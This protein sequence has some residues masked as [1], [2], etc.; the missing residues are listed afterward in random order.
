[1]T[2]LVKRLQSEYEGDYNLALTPVTFESVA[3]VKGNMLVKPMNGVFARSLDRCIALHGDHYLLVPYENILN[4]L[5]DALDKYG[6]DIRDAK[7][8]F[9]V[10]PTLGRMKL[11]ILFGDT[12]RYGTYI[13]Q[14][15][16]NDKLQFG[17]EVV[18]SYDASIMYKLQVMFLRL[19]CANGMKSFET[20]NSSLRRHTTN[21]VLEDSFKKLQNLNDTFDSFSNVMEAYQR[22][23]LKQEQVK[24]LFK[25][26]A[27]GSSSKEWL[28]HEVLENKDKPTL[29]DVYNSFTNY[30]SH[31]QRALSDGGTKKEPKFKLASS[32]MDS[33]K[34]DDRRNLEVQNFITKNK[35]F[36]YFYHQGIANNL[37]AN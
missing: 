34:S 37:R 18:S 32:N 25:D 16:S 2:T 28:L 10:D 5:S 17:I 9:S 31:N 12:S 20:I 7:L 14:H 33:I 1:M 24:D 22:V 36:V 27:N 35:N 6:I 29:Y 15:N 3:D 4:G 26:F 8:L 23:E 13:M 21:F 11:R 30:S 19:I